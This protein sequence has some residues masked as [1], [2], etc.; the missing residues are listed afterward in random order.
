MNMDTVEL[1][2]PKTGVVSVF[3]E[4]IHTQIEDNDEDDMTDEEFFEY[5]L[6]IAENDSDDAVIVNDEDYVPSQAEKEFYE[7]M[8]A[9]D[10]EVSDEFKN[11]ISNIDHED[12]MTVFYMLE[13]GK[14]EEEVM[15]TWVKND[16]Q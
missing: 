8:I 2:N 9:A 1:E 14:T 16:V 6:E 3:E 13:D 10:I 4:S 12:F 5:L 7:K 15:A 11:F